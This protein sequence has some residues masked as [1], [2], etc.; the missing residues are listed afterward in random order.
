MRIDEEYWE[1]TQLVFALRAVKSFL[2]EQLQESLIN[3]QRHQDGFEGE[4]NLSRCTNLL[5]CGCCAHASR[6]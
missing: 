6:F 1:H 5:R 2:V 4:R 3:V